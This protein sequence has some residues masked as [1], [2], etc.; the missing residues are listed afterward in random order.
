MLMVG[1]TSEFTDKVSFGQH[2][3]FYTVG[4]LAPELGVSKKGLHAMASITLVWGRV[5]CCGGKIIA[6]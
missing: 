5:F 2:S 4:D 6:R 1:L 3:Q